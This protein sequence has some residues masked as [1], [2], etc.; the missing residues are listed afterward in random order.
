MQMGFRGDGDSGVVRTS[1][2]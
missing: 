1:D 2:F